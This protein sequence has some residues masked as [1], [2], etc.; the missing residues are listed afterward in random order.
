[1][2]KDQSKC[3]KKDSI[4]KEVIACCLHYRKKMMSKQ[5]QLPMLIIYNL[6]T[7]KMDHFIQ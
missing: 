1:M 3:N 7:Q 2:Y 4:L 5:G 6:N